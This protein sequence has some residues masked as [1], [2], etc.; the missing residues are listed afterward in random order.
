MLPYCE[1]INNNGSI[2]VLYSL[3][4][5]LLKIVEN[6]FRFHS[7]LIDAEQKWGSKTNGTWN[8]IVGLIYKRVN[9]FY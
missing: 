2:T 1:I 3:E 6:K 9:F 7:K 4:T 5:E 8:G